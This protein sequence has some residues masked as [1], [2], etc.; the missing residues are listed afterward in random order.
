MRSVAQ[1]ID[2][3]SEAVSDNNGFGSGVIKLHVV[4]G[5]TEQL[6]TI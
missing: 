5:K 6:K 3:L 2:G 4:E 1:D